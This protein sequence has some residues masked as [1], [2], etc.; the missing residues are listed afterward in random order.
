[1]IEIIVVLLSTYKIH[2][3]NIQTNTYIV[4]N[5]FQ[6]DHNTS[7]LHSYSSKKV[8][9]CM[10]LMTQFVSEMGIAR[11]SRIAHANKEV[12]RIQHHLYEKTAFR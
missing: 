8:N 10:Y 2:D 12:I 7:R 9:E 5:K 11:H 1:M 3:Q 6:G 4:Q